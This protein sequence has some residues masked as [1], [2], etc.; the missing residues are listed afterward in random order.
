M[1]SLKHIVQI[2]NY[3]QSKVD[4]ITK[5]IT[6]RLYV[7]DNLTQSELD[8]LEYLTEKNIYEKVGV[9]FDNGYKICDYGMGETY[10][11]VKIS[12]NPETLLSQEGIDLLLNY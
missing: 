1:N 7:A 2:V 12:K 9:Y 4:N 8:A 5:K 3:G 10:G 11:F 6:E